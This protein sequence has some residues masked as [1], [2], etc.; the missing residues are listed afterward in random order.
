MMIFKSCFSLVEICTLKTAVLLSTCDGPTVRSW[1]LFVCLIASWLSY[2]GT[3]DAGKSSQRIRQLIDILYYHNW[4]T[5]R[6]RTLLNTLPNPSY[7]S[8][9]K[10]NQIGMFAKVILNVNML[11]RNFEKIPAR[12]LLSM[13]SSVLLYDDENVTYRL[14]NFSFLQSVWPRP[15]GAKQKIHE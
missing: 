2:Y 11:D 9:Y 4:L 8:F 12:Q 5:Q 15:A 7:D 6:S 1:G 14:S 3:C 10:I 13:F